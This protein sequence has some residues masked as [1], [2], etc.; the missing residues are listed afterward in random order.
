MENQLETVDKYAGLD[1]KELVL[2]YYRLD[3]YLTT[4]NKNLDKNVAMKQVETPMGI[5]NAIKEV[6]KEH[7]EKFKT[8]EYY[9]TLCEVV[10]KLKP[11]VDIIIECDD[12]IKKLAETFK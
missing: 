7:V 3:N 9:I 4:L 10:N 6:P 5:A 12:S 11:I 1:N 2:V 8:T